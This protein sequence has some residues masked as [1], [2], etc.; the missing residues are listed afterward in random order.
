MLSHLVKLQATISNDHGAT[1]VE[2]RPKVALVVIMVAVALL[3]A[4]LRALFNNF[5]PSV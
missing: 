5:A 4:N 3:V 1:A 2:Y